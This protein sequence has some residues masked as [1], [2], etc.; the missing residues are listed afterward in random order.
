MEDRKKTEQNSKYPSQYEELH[1]QKYHR[2]GCAEYDYDND[3][4]NRL[5]KRGF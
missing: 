5:R 1:Y 4:Y 3:Y 2:G